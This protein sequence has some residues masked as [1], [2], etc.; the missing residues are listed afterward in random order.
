MPFNLLQL[1]LILYPL[2]S[3]L[4][5][6]VG[7]LFN[8]INLKK[9]RLKSFYPTNWE[10]LLISLHETNHLRLVTNL[11]VSTVLE[12]TALLI[13]E[14][15]IATELGLGEGGRQVEIRTFFKVRINLYCTFNKVCGIV[16]EIFEMV[17]ITM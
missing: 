14:R 2:S 9:R 1:K 17:N 4:S 5:K 12:T 11:F 6:G 13:Q 15:N 10:N 16:K 7:K 8:T 3:E